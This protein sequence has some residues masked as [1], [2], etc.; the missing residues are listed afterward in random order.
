MDMDNC[1]GKSN[2]IPWYL[3]EDL[4]YF[5]KLTEGHIIIMGRKTFDSL[6]NGPLKNRLHIVISR[7]TVNYDSPNVIVTDMIHIFDVINTT[8]D[9]PG[10]KNKKIFIIGGSEIYTLF[11]DYCAEIYITTVML[12]NIQGTIYFNTHLLKD[13]TLVSTSPKHVS[14][15]NIEYTHSVYVRANIT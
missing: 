4:Q 9:I 14:K 13:F 12:S 1:I 15:N 2:S 6:P 11:I 8:R 3:P 7:N 5:K 10:Y